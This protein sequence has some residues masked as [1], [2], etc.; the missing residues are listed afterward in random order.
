MFEDVRSL[1][2]KVVLD[3]TW[4]DCWC[5]N[6]GNRNFNSIKI[7]GL[8]HESASSTENKKEKEEGIFSDA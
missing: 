1:G 2:S 4:R 3:W 7:V 6:V 5:L 8:R